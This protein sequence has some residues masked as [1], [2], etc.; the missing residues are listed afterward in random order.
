[1]KHTARLDRDILTPFCWQVL[2]ILEN[3]PEEIKC[4]HWRCVSF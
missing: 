2:H 3:I 1:M 4:V